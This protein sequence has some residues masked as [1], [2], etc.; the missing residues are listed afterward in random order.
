M[1]NKVI[2]R[3]PNQQVCMLFPSNPLFHDKQ[4][5]VSQWFSFCST[6]SYRMLPNRLI[7]Q[8]AASAEEGLFSV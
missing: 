8:T 5:V 3:Y 4:Y 2:K 7:S 6:D 1:L